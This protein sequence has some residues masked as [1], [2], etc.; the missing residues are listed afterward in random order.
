MASAK[1][2]INHIVQKMSK[3]ELS[4]LL[5][6]SPTK[7]YQHTRFQLYLD[8][9]LKTC[10][11]SGCSDPTG[12]EEGCSFLSSYLNLWRPFKLP[13]RTLLPFHHHLNKDFN[14]FHLSPDSRLLVL[15]LSKKSLSKQLKMV[16]P[17]KGLKSE[18]AE[19][20]SDEMRGK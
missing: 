7:P 13:A 16:Q 9:K 20:A 2:G 12:C 18:A 8:R 3:A 5:P 6:I 17:A 10:G 14:T 19:G 1:A 11:K 4:L 15:K